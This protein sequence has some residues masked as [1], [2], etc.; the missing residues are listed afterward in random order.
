MLSVVRLVVPVRLPF[1]LT[2]HPDHQIAS[3]AGVLH[4]DVSG[5]NVLFEEVPD[6]NGNLKGFL[7]DWDYAEFT[8]DGLR[9]FHEAF[10]EREKQTELYQSIDKSLKDFTVCASFL[11]VSFGD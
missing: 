8:E 7:V 4:R 3:N 2:I 1:Q 5:G 9:L 10:P 11:P 6:A